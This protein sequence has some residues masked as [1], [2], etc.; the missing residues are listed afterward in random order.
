MKK[1][2]LVTGGAGFIGRQTLQPLIDSGFSVHVADLH[3][4]EKEHP[5]IA[6]HSGNVFDLNFVKKLF[7]DIKPTHL[8]NFA[9]ITR[10]G[11]YWSSIEN[12][13][14]VNGSMKLLEAFAANGGQRVVMAGTCAEYDWQNG[15]CIENIT[16]HA[17]ATIY[18]SC[19][20]AM[21]ELLKSFCRAR[22]LSWAWGRIFFTFGPFEN[23]KRFLPA[24]ILPLLKKQPAACSHGNQIRDFLATKEIGAAFGGL[25]SSAVE[26]PVNIASGQPI[27]L[28]QI[29]SFIEEL[30]ETKGLVEFGKIPSPVD[31]TPVIL[32]ATE[33]LNKE[34]G[35]FPAKTV[36]QHITETVNWW[37]QNG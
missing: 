36:F 24:I 4:L 27:T 8:L 21:F 1:T 22:G 7:A 11:E 9:W 29:A 2:I 30:T 10:H 12:I 32:A 31:E 3:S 35:W 25:V 5:E 23:P 37:R 26:G 19:K 18:G 20:L 14:S 33:R 17:P 16:R 15:I 34:V 6:W 28:K 13:D